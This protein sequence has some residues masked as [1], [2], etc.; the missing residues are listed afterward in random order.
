VLCHWWGGR[1]SL[2][3][4]TRKW[5]ISEISVLSNKILCR[6]QLR[7]GHIVRS[8][9]SNKKWRNNRMKHSPTELL[10]VAELVKKFPA[11]MEKWRSITVVTTA[12]D[13][14]IFPASGIPSASS[15][16]VS[17]TNIFRCVNAS[18][19]ERR[20]V[21]SYPSTYL[22]ARIK[23]S[24]TVRIFVKFEIEDFNE[25]PLRKSKFGWNRSQISGNWHENVVT[26]ILLTA[27]RYC[28]SSATGTP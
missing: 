14:S 22:S 8:T 10:V 2:L 28:D 13:W 12:R 15:S 24:H 17:L 21:S 20:L 1:V 4:R 16:T 11:F 9:E 27:V 7:T 3:G 5:T 23:S 25:N 19:E 6:R 18:Y 26:S